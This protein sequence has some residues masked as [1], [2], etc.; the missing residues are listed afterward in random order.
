[1]K[2]LA[3]VALMVGMIALLTGI[4]HI[5]PSKVHHEADTKKLK[6]E[7]R[8]SSDVISPHS[9]FHDF[10]V[11]DLKNDHYRADQKK[12]LKTEKGT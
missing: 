9:V 5:Y 4:S 2:I 1:M 6:K 10:L 8:D 7:L 11:R 3:V 12:L